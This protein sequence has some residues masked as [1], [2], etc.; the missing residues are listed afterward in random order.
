MEQVGAKRPW[1]SFCRVRD[2]KARCNA[3][4]PFGVSEGAKEQPAAGWERDCFR[5]QPGQPGIG[6]IRQESA[7]LMAFTAGLVAFGVCFV[8]GLPGDWT[9][10][11]IAG[12][13]VVVG[14]VVTAAG[15]VAA[16]AVDGAAGWL[17][18]FWAVAALVIAIVAGEAVADRLATR[19]WGEPR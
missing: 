14:Q 13:I 8:T 18:G 6:C 2:P 16:I 15:V 1:Q 10:R 12:A 9:R 3:G 4:Q 19:L 5:E 17:H 7:P 11:R